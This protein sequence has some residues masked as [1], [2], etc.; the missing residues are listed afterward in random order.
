M[1]VVLIC[2]YSM[3]I[4]GGVQ[5]QVLGLAR[6][7]RAIGV[8]ARVIAPCDGPPPEPGIISV[9][10]TRGVAMN[11]SVAPIASGKVVASRTIEALRAYEPDVIHIH[12]PF[13]PGP[14][15]AA[16]LSASVPIVATFHAAAFRMSLYERTRGVLAWG[17]SH[18]TIRTA[19]S[20]AA[21]KLLVEN[22]GPGDYRIM[23][24]GV[25]V[26]RFAGAT[27]YASRRPALLFV[28]RH[29]ERKGLGVLLDAFAGL[30]RDADLW[31]IGEGPETAALERRHRNRV[32][33]L[34]RVSDTELA[35]R[36]A[37]AAAFVAPALHGE[38]F[39]V[40]LLEAM[41]ART[42]VV[43]SSIDGYAA[44]ARDGIE[45][46]L[47]PPGDPD[48]LR[49]ALREVL[50]DPAARAAR[51]TAGVVR[52]EEFSLRRLAEAYVELYEEARTQV[53]VP[54]R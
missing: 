43:A 35:S 28:G 27:P 50:D 14:G 1:R 36:L 26:D 13:A 54:A 7:L 17:L 8:G 10:G 2:P 12:E 32:E 45:A 44:V 29:E 4:P 30:E 5:G 42:P 20:D 22:F 33:W 38:S 48:A 40:V 16:L 6:H 39:G 11:G 25:D 46:R 53:P 24:N 52:A 23:P 49:V 19:V 18:V 31:V 3:S 9:G 51:V 41:A 21:A 15:H 37:G 47:V 34:G